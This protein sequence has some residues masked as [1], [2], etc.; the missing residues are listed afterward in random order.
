MPLPE[1]A[2]KELLS[3]GYLRLVA[4]QAGFIPGVD[5]LDFGVDIQLRHV[6][7]IEEHGR[8]KFRASGFMIDV[9]L[10]ATCER[11]AQFVDGHVLYD[12]DSTAFND[13]VRRTSSPHTIP[14]ILGLLVLPDIPD[15]WLSLDESAL[16]LRRCTYVWRPSP[17]DVLTQNTATKRIRIPLAS[18]LELG[19]F[20]SIRQEYLS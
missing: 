9:Q 2:A 4:G 13:L 5:E 11:D 20:E 17:D 6:D 12:L 7:C 8:S 15:E 16:L 10:K 3:R 19:T 14:I 1:S 18:R